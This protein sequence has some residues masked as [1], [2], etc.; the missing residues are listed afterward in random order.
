MKNKVFAN[1]TLNLKKIKYIGLDMDHT[2]IR[3]KTE[4]FERLAHRVMVQKLVNNL[5][6][7]K[8]ILN[9]KFEYNRSIR[10]LVI[11]KVAGNLLKLSR[12]GGIK[13]C[14]HGLKEIEYSKR[15]KLFADTFIDISDPNFDTI[16]TNFSISFANLFS[17]L[18]ELK[19]TTEIHKLPEYNQIADDIAS[20]LDTA[21][22][23]GSLKDVVRENLS[24]YIIQDESVVRDIE[25]FIKHGKKIFILTNSEYPYTKLLLDYAINPYLK[26]H[27][28][29]MD[30]FEF[31]IT[32]SRK[33]RF[34]YD[35]LRFMKIDTETGQMTNL[36]SKLTPGVYQGGS[37]KV[38]TDDLNLDPGHILYIGDHIY[39]DVVRLKKDCAWRTA[40]IL[41]ELEDEVNNNEKSEAINKEIE[42]LMSQKIP[43][44]KEID[45]LIS[46]EIENNHKNNKEKIN[47]LLS[48][49]NEL[50]QKISPL[51]EKI[52]KLYNPYWGEIMRT[53]IE[54]SY[55]GYQVERFADIYMAKIGDF[56]AESPRSY[57]RS[58]KRLMAHD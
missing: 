14:Y 52:Q 55:F 3:Y 30:L 58:Q 9:L 5:D 12:F 36:K 51:I 28:S 49:I 56:F 8:S 23:D 29:W 20:A 50:D 18:V 27:S 41:E 43:V 44:E 42:S 35:S 13:H 37:A 33:P 15:K 17:Q 1:R 6:Y 48:Q 34:F 19:D 32:G 4:N 31:T 40:L 53:G 2:L 47:Q 11:D 45:R 57:Y 38:F 10:G 46:D 26:D 7:P 54:E 21:H 16:D 25:K 39:G 24:D 22:Q